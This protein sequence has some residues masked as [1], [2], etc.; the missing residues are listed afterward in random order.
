[1]RF[2]NHISDVREITQPF[3]TASKINLVHCNVVCAKLISAFQITL[4]YVS[5]VAVVS[6]NY[7]V[8][9]GET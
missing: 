5:G 8:V 2:E 6:G 1:M 4:S 9:A 3:V 7:A